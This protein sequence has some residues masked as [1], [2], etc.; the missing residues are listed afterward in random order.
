MKKHTVLYS[1]PWLV[2]L[3]SHI[4]KKTH[5]CLRD[6]VEY[7]RKRKS[8]F[9]KN[10]TVISDNFIHGSFPQTLSGCIN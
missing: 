8:P 7:S 3:Q 1:L 9:T 6:L 2:E 4:G 5:L 10:N